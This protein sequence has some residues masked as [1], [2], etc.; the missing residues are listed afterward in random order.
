MFTGIVQ[1]KLPLLHIE[2]HND[3]ATLTFEFPSKMR[4]GLQIG[5][6]VAINGTCLT[7]RTI[8]GNKVSFDAIA[9]TLNITNLGTLEAGKVVNIERAARFGD[10]IGG[11]VL[12]GH[13]MQQVRVLAVQD[14]EF[15][16]VVWFERPESL[17]PFLLDKGFVALN[18]CSLTIAEVKDCCFSVF[19]IPETRDVTVF[20]EVQVGDLINIEIDSQTQAVVETVKRLLAN[21]E[22][23]AK[24]QGN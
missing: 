23:L 17:A 21:P 9:Q 1:T 3:F 18:G 4:E 16:R 15:N 8:E 22:A 20:G 5:A 13:V 14:S 24:L 10:E 12:S 11:H 6:S 7:V 2:R 19:L